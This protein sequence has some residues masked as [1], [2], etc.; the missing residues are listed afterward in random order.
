MAVPIDDSKDDWV[1]SN[2]GDS[3]SECENEPKPWHKSDHEDSV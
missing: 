1:D 2:E 3:D